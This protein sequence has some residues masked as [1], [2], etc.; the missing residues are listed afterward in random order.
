MVANK[1]LAR[2]LA[3]MLRNRRV[4]SNTPIRPIPGRVSERGRS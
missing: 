3:S 2:S 4:S 1:I